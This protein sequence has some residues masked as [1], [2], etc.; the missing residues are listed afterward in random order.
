[1]LNK[2]SNKK[3]IGTLFDWVL[4][5]AIKYFYIIETEGITIFLLLY[6]L[7]H[8]NVLASSQI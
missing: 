8:N 4:D 5:N 2:T 1:M 7:E 6:I 3:V